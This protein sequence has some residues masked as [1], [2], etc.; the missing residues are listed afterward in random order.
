MSDEAL[1]D[2]QRELLARI[3]QHGGVLAAPFGHMGEDSL[4]PDLLADIE[5]LEASG[6]LRVERDPDGDPRRLE[7]T[8]QGYEALEME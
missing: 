3:L 6:R 1:E 2:S 7:L 8:P 4:L 5:A